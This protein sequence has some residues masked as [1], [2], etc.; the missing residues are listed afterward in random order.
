MGYTSDNIQILTWED[1]RL[2]G[3]RENSRV[4]TPIVMHKDGEKLAEF[5]SI[6]AAVE[7]TGFSQGNISMCCQGKRSHVGGYVFS[8]R[9]DK[10][11]KH[12]H[13]LEGM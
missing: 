5:E 8:Y 1:N 4:T 13:L 3:D 7:I 6:K 11:R 12:P 2:K 9:G 10:F